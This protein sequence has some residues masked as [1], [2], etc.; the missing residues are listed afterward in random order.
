LVR[1]VRD[2]LRRRQELEL[3]FDAKARRGANPLWSNAPISMSTWRLAARARGLRRLDVLTG[4]CGALLR[5]SGRLRSRQTCRRIRRM[6]SA[7][8]LRIRPRR[9]CPR[10]G[11]VLPSAEG[12]RVREGSA[13]AAEHPRPGSTRG[14]PRSACRQ[15]GS[16]TDGCGARGR[17]QSANQP[18]S[19]SANQPSDGCGARGRCQSANQPISKSA[20]QPIS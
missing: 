1:L 18:I 9:A 20:D 4:Q 5:G 6:A 17:C 8:R 14:T 15:P 19:Q 11:E 3:S 2:Q 13:G 12:A 10:D 16:T 7:A